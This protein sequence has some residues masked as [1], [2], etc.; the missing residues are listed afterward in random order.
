MRSLHVGC[1]A[2]GALLV[3]SNEVVQAASP[4]GPTQGALHA[5]RKDT[6]G[7]ETT[8]EW[9]L[10]HTEVE[11]EIRGY[12]ARVKVKQTF[13]NPCDQPIEAVYVFPLPQDAAVNDMLIRVGERVIRGVIKKREEAKQIYE[14]A[15]QEG[16]TTALLEQ[17]RPNIFSQS[18]ANILPGNEIVVEITYDDLLPYEKGRYEFVFPMVVGPRYIPGT[19]TGKQ[20][21]GWAPD[22]DQVP[23]A[24]RITPPVLKPGERSGQDIM[25]TVK[26]DAGLPVR[27]IESPSHSLEGQ[28]E[29]FPLE[30][31]CVIR[32]APRDTIPNKDFVLRYRVAGEAPQIAL[33]S[34]SGGDGGWFML[35]FQPPEQAP[36]EQ[37]APKEM[38]FVLDTSGSM[39][40]EPLALVKQGIRRALEN[41]NPDDTF[42]VIRFSNDYS[43]FEPAPVPATRENIRRGLSWI[44]GLAASGGTEMLKPLCAALTFPPRE[45]RLRI[46]FFMTDGYVS[47]EAAILDAVRRNLGENSRLFTFGIGSSVNRYLLERLAEMGR[48]D[49]RYILLKD[50]PDEAV[51]EAYRRIRS[52]ILTHLRVDWAGL[53]VEDLSPAR[54][55]DLFAD[56]PMFILGRYRRA[57]AA[58]IRIHGRHGGEAVSYIIP[59]RLSDSAP[60]GGVLASLWARA[61][62]KELEAELYGGRDPDTVKT[63]TDLALKHRLMSAFTAF[64]AV[65]D[66]VVN[67]GGKLV[68][69][70]VPVEMP[71][72]VS[73]EGVFG[74]SGDVDRAGMAFGTPLAMKGMFAGRASQTRMRV[75]REAPACAVNF[76]V[77]EQA[78]PL[79]P[80]KPFILELRTPTE[81]G[82]EVLRVTEGGEIWLDQMLLGRLTRRQVRELWALLSAALKSPAE[83]VPWIRAAEVRLRICAD[84]GSWEPEVRV[85]TGPAADEI[86]GPWKPFLDYVDALRAGF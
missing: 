40:G 14:Q 78:D 62:I 11:A 50:R 65:E 20:A 58:D 7:E 61:R 3:V 64:V 25:I 12:V 39:S 48:G 36:K 15:K 45:D 10:K 38:I 8:V 84:D 68:T 32:L 24:S 72:G 34:E 22:T 30:G 4:K 41:L 60:E 54:A 79:E 70:Q 67:E 27:A 51:D 85:E 75:L 13:T 63:I 9:P 18:I 29:R 17:E 42:Q 49:V 57:G 26:L 66:K 80:I 33:L 59:V 19:P 77:L 28:P 2:L 83:R 81:S 46:V 82:E 37:V 31:P 69:I 76:E 47:N 21:G 43:S 55:R 16:K 86:P 53:E 74:R 52:P 71:E 35:M 56:Q 23:D 44:N 5:V 73:Y 1:L 6:N